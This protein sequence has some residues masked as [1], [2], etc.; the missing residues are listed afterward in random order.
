MRRDIWNELVLG[1]KW[2]GGLSRL[3]PP[4]MLT[5]LLSLPM[6]ALAY[7]APVPDL[8]VSEAMYTPMPKACTATMTSISM[9][10]TDQVSLIAEAGFGVD[11]PFG[12]TFVNKV[13]R[14]CVF[15]CDGMLQLAYCNEN[16]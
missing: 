11:V 16:L 12:C 9:A 10:D 8:P 7:A 1:L 6:F 13:G 2:L 3:E 4:T 15:E 14:I 5:T